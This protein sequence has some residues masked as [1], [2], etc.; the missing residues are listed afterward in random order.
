MLMGLNQD[1]AYVE[2]MRELNIRAI[3]IGSDFS[4]DLEKVHQNQYGKYEGLIIFARLCQFGGLCGFCYF[5]RHLFAFWKRSVQ[6]KSVLLLNRRRNYSQI[7]TDCDENRGFKVWLN[8]DLRYLTAIYDS[9]C[10]IIQRPS[11]S[12]TTQP[13]FKNIHRFLSI[14]LSSLGADNGYWSVKLIPKNE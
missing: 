5:K 7:V 14:S 10:H 9:I 13:S 3:V 4:K 12:N 1:C 2:R 8:Y 6:L 11:V